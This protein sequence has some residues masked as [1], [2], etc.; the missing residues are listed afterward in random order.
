MKGDVEKSLGW[1]PIPL[2]DR[3]NYAEVASMQVHLTIFI[4]SMYD[5]YTLDSFYFIS[6]LDFLEGFVFPATNC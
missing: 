3:N 6:R 2:F 5:F 4:L 1:T